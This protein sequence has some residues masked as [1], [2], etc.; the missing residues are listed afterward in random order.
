[1]SLTY[2]EFE[3]YCIDFTSRIPVQRDGWL[4]IKPTNKK[5]GY[6]CLKNH[7]IESTKSQLTTTKHTQTNTK[8]L[9]TFEYHIVYSQSYNVPVLYFKVTE[10][11]KLL[12]YDQV[13][14]EINTTLVPQYDNKYTFITQGVRNSLVHC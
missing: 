12:D 7:T 5:P 2:E 8:R 13:L 1:M 10:N 3:K 6:C 14:Q 9:L 4:W 11:N